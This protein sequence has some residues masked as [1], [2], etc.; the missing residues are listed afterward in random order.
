MAS[1]LNN[2]KRVDMLL[3]KKPN[4]QVIYIYLKQSICNH[5]SMLHP[6]VVATEKGA[7]RSPSTTVAN[8]IWNYIHFRI[9]TLENGI[10][11]V[12]PKAIG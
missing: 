11:F 1:A 9:N 6:G 4:H 2:L 3:N 7:F 5:N 10:K 12:I 8:F